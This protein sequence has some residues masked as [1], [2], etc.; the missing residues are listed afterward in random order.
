VIFSSIWSSNPFSAANNA[1]NSAL[2]SP[3]SDESISSLACL[4]ASRT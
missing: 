3:P 2:L 4:S 1:C